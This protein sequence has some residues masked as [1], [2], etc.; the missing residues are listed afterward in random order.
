MCSVS[1]VIPI[2][3]PVNWEFLSFTKGNKLNK[4]WECR[5]RGIPQLS[6]RA[7]TWTSWWGYQQPNRSSERFRRFTSITCSLESSEFLLLQ[8]VLLTNT[9]QCLKHVL[10]IH[11]TSFSHHTDNV[12]ALG[13]MVLP[14]IYPQQRAQKYLSGGFNPVVEHLSKW[15]TFTKKGVKMCETTT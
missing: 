4:N 3:Q 10:L 8:D 15:I 6:C 13:H 7:A 2:H 12:N 5:A 14:S 9:S 1:S 11:S